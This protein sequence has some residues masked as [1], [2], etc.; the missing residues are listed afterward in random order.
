M[1]DEALQRG[2]TQWYCTG[3]RRRLE[4]RPTRDDPGYQ[5]TVTASENEVT[6]DACGSVVRHSDR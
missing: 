5:D 4:N 2:P 6:H 3:C 1:T